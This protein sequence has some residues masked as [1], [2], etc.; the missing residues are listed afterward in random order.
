MSIKKRALVALGAAAAVLFVGAC[1]SGGGSGSSDSTIVEGVAGPSGEAVAGGVGRALQ[2]AEPRTL[3]PAAN[4]NFWS[5]SPLVFNALYGTL[6]INNEVTGEV[7]YRIAEDMSTTDGGKTFTL[8]LRDGVE[9][10]DGTPLDAAAVKIAWDRMRDPAVASVDLPQASMLEGTEVV[11]AQT[12][13]VTLVEPLPAFPQAVLQSSMNWIASPATLA[14]DQSV[15]DSNPIGAGPFTL[16]RWSRQDVIVLTKNENY[17]DAPRPYLDTLEVRTMGDPDQR[18]NTVLSGG[19]DLAAENRWQNLDRAATAGLQSSVIP[20]NGGVGLVLNMTRAPFDDPRAREALSLALDVDT[21]DTALYEGT[22]VVPETFFDESSPFFKDIPLS[23]HDP[24]RAQELFDELAA[25]GKPLD[26]TMSLFAN[27]KDVGE[28][29]QTQLSVFNNVE[30]HVKIIDFSEYNGIMGARDYDV[31][32]NAV[33]FGEPEPRIWIGLHST[34]SGNFSGIADPELDAALEKGRLSE[35][36]AERDA[37]Y[38][39]V[40]ER[41]SELNP[42]VFYTRAAPGVIAGANVGGVQ[43]YGIGSMLPDSL[44][45]QK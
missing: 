43:Q 39:V 31:V 19:A 40:Q 16:E 3:D 20:L 15:V 30:A 11:D 5:N 26:F 25:E 4:L 10:S 13:K 2:L 36:F 8:V 28:A 9:F 45:I 29:V 12:L 34:S 22:G 24:V 6:M 33:I 37:A 42:T 27:I 14:A 32:S 41:V 38:Q 7:E 44:W 1:G 18:Y 17:Y 35:D 23:E 21:I